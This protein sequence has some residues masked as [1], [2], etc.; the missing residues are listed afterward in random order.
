[1]SHDAF[2]TKIFHVDL[3]LMIFSEMPVYIHFQFTGQEPLESI[4]INVNVYRVFGKK[5]R[6]PFF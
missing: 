4:Q 2:L 3:K 5:Q 1:M 6:R